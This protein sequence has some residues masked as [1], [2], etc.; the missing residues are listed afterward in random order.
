MAAAAVTTFQCTKCKY[1][2]PRKND[3]T[4][5]EMIH[6]VL[7]HACLVSGCNHRFLTLSNLDVHMNARHPA[8]AKAWGPLRRVRKRPV[9]AAGVASGGGGSN[10][11]ASTYVETVILDPDT[12]RPV[13][14]RTKVVSTASAAAAVSAGAA[15]AETATEP[16]TSDEFDRRRVEAYLDHIGGDL[17]YLQ[18]VRGGRMLTYDGW[19]DLANRS[20]LWL[21]PSQVNLVYPRRKQ[22]EGGRN[23]VPIVH[24]SNIKTCVL[25]PGDKQKEDK[26]A[27]AAAATPEVVTGTVA[28]A[29]DATDDAADADEVEEDDDDAPVV[30]S[31]V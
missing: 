14:K 5:H 22:A 26:G 11:D 3:V 19:M 17:D 23:L 7:P 8:E 18:A 24:Q 13:R 1:T 29:D 15:T 12:Q 6:G 21:T 31:I 30:T 27:E 4:K 9:E 16:I 25:I 20:N 2:S 10:G 28:A